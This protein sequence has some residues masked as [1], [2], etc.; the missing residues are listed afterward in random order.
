MRRSTPRKGRVTPVTG[1][2]IKPRECV[3]TTAVFEGRPGEWAIEK[4]EAKYKS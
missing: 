3:A 2:V 1:R 4:L